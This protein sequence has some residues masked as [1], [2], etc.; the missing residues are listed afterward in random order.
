MDTLSE[1]KNLTEAGPHKLEVFQHF[2]EF[3]EEKSRQ[4]VFETDPILLVSFIILC[5]H[6]FL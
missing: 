3:I 4:R 6:K 1:S 5:K 2:K